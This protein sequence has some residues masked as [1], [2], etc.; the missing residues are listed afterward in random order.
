[1]WMWMW[2]SWEWMF[3]D[4][5]E[6]N[7]GE[8]NRLKITRLTDT[9][10]TSCHCLALYSVWY[11]LR[12]FLCGW[13]QCGYASGLLTCWCDYSNTCVCANV[14]ECVRSRVCMNTGPPAHF[15]QTSKEVWINPACRNHSA[16]R[17]QFHIS[18]TPAAPNLHAH[19]YWNEQMEF[20]HAPNRHPPS[21]R[22]D[23]TSKEPGIHS[24]LFAGGEAVCHRRWCGGVLCLCE[25]VAK[26]G[27]HVFLIKAGQ[28]CFH[29]QPSSKSHFPFS[30]IRPCRGDVMVMHLHTHTHMSTSK[31]ICITTSNSLL[32]P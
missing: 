30:L 9:V 3:E 25:S 16:C 32:N 7:P 11:K 29:F 28:L 21:L 23:K 1:M 5:Q 24:D 6:L 20:Y 13:I 4:A 31:C 26:C 19:S 14:R 15:T 27:Y 22:K 18:A 17:P 10:K 2:M 8:C 12:C